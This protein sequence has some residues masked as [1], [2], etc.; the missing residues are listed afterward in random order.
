MSTAENIYSKGDWIVH[1]NY[2]VGQV[3]GKDKKSLD[4]EKMTFLKV[5]TFNSIYWL[6]VTNLDVDHIRPLASKYQITRALTLIRKAPKEMDKDHK[7]RSKDI[8]QAFSD[9]S[10]YTKARMIRDLNGR[11]VTIRLNQ[12]EGDAFDKMKKQLLNEW[13]VISG[14]DEDTLADKLDTALQ[15]SSSKIVFEDD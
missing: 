3:K 5:K 13:S 12:S 1:A 10:L 14:A 11:R 15:K 7:Q 9:V 8:S 4:G 6:P 2:G